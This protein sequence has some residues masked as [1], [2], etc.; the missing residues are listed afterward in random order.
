M[1][2]FS[3][4]MNI[5]S[6]ATRFALLQSY[7]KLVGVGE[8]SARCLAPASSNNNDE[9]DA[10]TNQEPFLISIVVLVAAGLVL[11]AVMFF[12]MMG[13]KGAAQAA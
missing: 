9:D 12:F 7:L 13:A 3:N 6:R 4:A 2:R 10:F 5:A 1:R 11:A 8:G